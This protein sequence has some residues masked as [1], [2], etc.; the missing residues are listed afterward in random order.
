LIQTGFPPCKEK[1][2]DD[3]KPLWK[4][5][6]ELFL[7]HGLV[8]WGKR[9]LIPESFRRR[10]LDTLHASHQGQE[11]TLRRARQAVFWPNISSDI[12]NMIRSC[13]ECAVHLPS[14][15]KEPW[16]VQPP[17]TRPFECVGVDLFKYA[18]NEY[19]VMVDRYSGW[20][21]VAKCG[22]S[23]TTSKVIYLLKQWM[24]DFGIPEKL[25]SDNGP[26]FSSMEFKNWT[27]KWG[28]AHDPSSPHYP[29]ANGLAEAGVKAAKT[30]LMKMSPSGDLRNEAFQLGLL[31]LRNTPKSHGHSP[32]QLLFGQP[33]RT[34]L[35]L[36]RSQF[37]S[38]WRKQ[39]KEA[40]SRATKLKEK[41]VQHYNSTAKPL[42]RLKCGEVIRVQ[43]P[44][45]QEWNQIGVVID[46]HSR[47]RSYT[48]RT[49]SGKIFWRNRRF[50]RRFYPSQSAPREN[51][52]PLTQIPRRST[53]RRLPPERFAGALQLDR[54]SNSKGGHVV[55]SPTLPRGSEESNRAGMKLWHT[56]CLEGLGKEKSGKLSSFTQSH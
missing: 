2:D 50:L 46:I 9:I 33:I 29:Q 52:P 49:E 10:V 42:S 22:P 43:D 28:I 27:N 8:V 47:G 3:L 12:K 54:G 24:T 7:D 16:L 11:R 38:E 1:L 25:I 51:E 20:I 34:Q 26:Q 4:V 53:R 19:I 35:P 41:A 18:G 55:C 30:L 31:E 39:F 6:D 48:I 36:H 32:A 14:H 45:T 5:K 44:R 13:P 21:N 56:G 17:S 40:D 23:A 15:Q 37:T